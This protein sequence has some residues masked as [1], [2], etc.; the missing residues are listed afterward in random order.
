MIIS[1]KK[2]PRCSKSQKKLP[3]TRCTMPAKCMKRV[4]DNYESLVQFLEECLE[5]KLYQEAKAKILG[6][7]LF[8]FIFYFIII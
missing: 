2:N 6:W 7:H 3:V 1:R 5:K 4:I 8:I